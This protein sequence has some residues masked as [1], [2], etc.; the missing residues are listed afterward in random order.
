MKVIFVQGPTASGKSQWALDFASEFQ[1]SVV[2]CDSVQAYADLQ[3]GSAA[4]TEEDKKVAPHYLYQYVQFPDELTVGNYSRDFFQ[5]LDGIQNEMPRS[6]GGD[7]KKDFDSKI[8]FVVGGT[9]FYF[10]ALEKGLYPVLK[11]PEEIKY[12]LIEEMKNGLGRERLYQEL[13]Q[14]DPEAAREIHANDT[15]R[16]LRAL[17]VYRAFKKPFSSF[18][19]EFEA[20]QKPFP[21]PL[22]KIGLK[23]PREQLKLRIQKRTQQML[24]GGLID[25]TENLL[26]KYDSSWAPLQSVGYKEVTDFLE[27]RLAKEDLPELMNIAT[28]QLAKRQMTWFQRDQNLHWFDASTEQA[29]ARK[30]IE[31]FLKK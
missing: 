20:S 31:D 4:P 15:Y 17:E 5:T 10:Q 19:K 8:V 28:S 30:S 24:A 27:K 2:N 11:V 25:E 9:G 16:I 13:T 29:A 7:I 26:Q 18:R 3:I 23:W 14:V 22:L 6:S 1:G 21:Y 12:D